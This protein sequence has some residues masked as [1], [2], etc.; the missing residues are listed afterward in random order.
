MKLQ[1]RSN[2]FETNSSSVHAIT[3]SKNKLQIDPF[4]IN[5][6]FRVGNFG[7]NHVK[8]F[9]F[10]DK[11]SYLWTC[12]V[13]HFVVYK[14]NT[15]YFNNTDPTY[16]RYKNT[17]KKILIDFGF[18]EDS[19]WFQ[20][21]F[22]RNDWG[23]L[24]TGG[25]DHNPGRDFI[26]GLIFNRDRL[27]RYLFNDESCI[28]TWNDNEWYIS[29]RKRIQQEKDILPEN[30]T[31]KEWREWYRRTQWRHFDIPHNTEWKYLKTN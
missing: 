9:N 23:Y 12:I 3:V 10:K 14:N 17:I 7:W 26:E 1:I 6:D 8:Y 4:Y 21:E 11:A 13:N 19:I 18:S 25:I 5:C 16:L 29:P 15:T 20:E 24:K 2:I 27:I 31:S 22:K 28:T 30:Y